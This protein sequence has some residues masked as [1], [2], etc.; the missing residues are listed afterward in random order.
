MST[1]PYVIESDEKGEKVYD[2]YS[3][4]LK[5]RIVFISGKFEEKMA[6]SV[7]AQLLFLEAADPNGDI[8][9]Y[10]NSSGGDITAMYAIYDTMQ[11]IHSDIVT[12]GF[13]EVAS[14]G[15]FI[16]AA[17]TKG[18]RFALKNTNIMIHELSGGATGTATDMEIKMKHA[19]NLRERMAKHFAEMTGQTLT[20]M[21][22]DME[23]DY[24]MSSEEAKKYGLIDKIQYKRKG[25]HK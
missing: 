8:S 12:I 24:Y 2:L 9:I 21:K 5:D 11:Y 19:L 4:L 10:I 3:R 13:G 22:K 17:G 14:A 18:K 15:A 7:V 20:K 25:K 1:V 6:N 23:R 16:L